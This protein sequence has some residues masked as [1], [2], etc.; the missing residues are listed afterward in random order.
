MCFISV[1]KLLCLVPSWWPLLY[2]FTLLECQLVFIRTP[3]QSKVAWIGDIYFLGRVFVSETPPGV[4]NP[5]NLDVN[6]LV[7]RT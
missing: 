5:E 7:Y 3:C 1:V 4:T 6:F 2:R